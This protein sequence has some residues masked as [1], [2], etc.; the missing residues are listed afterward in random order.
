MWSIQVLWNDVWVTVQRGFKSYLDADWAIGEWRAKNDCGGNPFR[1][2]EEPDE[3]T[4]W[5][6]RIASRSRR[7]EQM[8]TRM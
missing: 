8:Q 2:Y 5:G 4:P 6:E 3:T 7:K 1:A